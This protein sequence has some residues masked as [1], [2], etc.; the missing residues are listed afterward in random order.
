MATHYKCLR[1]QLIHSVL[2]EFVLF[3]FSAF[4]SDLACEDWSTQST[5]AFPPDPNY[6]FPVLH[7]ASQRRPFLSNAHFLTKR[8]AT[9]EFYV[10]IL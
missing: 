10:D 2:I 7:F 5:G 8:S 6:V 4:G 3:V 1:L 9:D